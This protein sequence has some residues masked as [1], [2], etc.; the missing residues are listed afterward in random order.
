M[1]YTINKLGLKRYMLYNLLRVLEIL[2]N[3][4][5]IIIKLP[6]AIIFYIAIEFLLFEPKKTKLNNKIENFRKETN[7]ILKQ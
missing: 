7:N 4:L 3:L 2:I 5:Y 6:F 1:K